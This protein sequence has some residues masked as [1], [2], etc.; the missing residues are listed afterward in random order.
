MGH[1]EVDAYVWTCPDCGSQMVRTDEEKLFCVGTYDVEGPTGE[2]M[3]MRLH[4]PWVHAE[5]H[6]RAQK[7][8]D[9][10]A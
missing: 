2:P 6:F 10:E 9:P 1:I 7:W 5:A 3:I 8:A 4:L